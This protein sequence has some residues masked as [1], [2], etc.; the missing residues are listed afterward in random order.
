MSARTGSRSDTISV[1][2]VGISDRRDAELV[3]ICEHAVEFAAGG[4]AVAGQDQRRVA[5]V[6]EAHVAACI[7]APTMA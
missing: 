3:P 2:Q 7:E 6:E 4:L 1:D 5:E